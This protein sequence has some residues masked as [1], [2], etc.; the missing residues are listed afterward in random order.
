MLPPSLY[1]IKVGNERRY[2]KVS[3]FS[4]IIISAIIIVVLMSQ[5]KS[6][7]DAEILEK[8]SKYMVLPEESPTIATINDPEKLKE[9]IFFKEAGKGDKLFLFEKSERAILY[10]LE[11]DRI[12][13]A[14]S[15][16]E[17]GIQIQ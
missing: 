13:N 14:G 9:Y 6:T 2:F 1:K 17:S 11:L 16:A 8:I 12:L 4:A 10:S 15:I 3:I 7:Q 5:G